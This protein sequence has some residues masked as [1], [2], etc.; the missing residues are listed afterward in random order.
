M[1]YLPARDPKFFANLETNDCVSQRED[2]ITKRDGILAC[3]RT[4]H[5]RKIVL[6]DRALL[7]V[8]T[9]NK[10]RKKKH[11]PPLTCVEDAIRP[12]DYGHEVERHGGD[13]WLHLRANSQM[14]T[15]SFKGREKTAFTTS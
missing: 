12:T 9:R 1:W 13:L 14:L 3:D 6:F 15:S 11:R 5:P 10:K 8:T 2:T 4:D 7:S